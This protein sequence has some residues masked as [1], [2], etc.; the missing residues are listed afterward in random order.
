MRTAG[1]SIVPRRTA[2]PDDGDSETRYV[3]TV[4]FQKTEG[5]PRHDRQRS[6]DTEKIIWFFIHGSFV[7]EDLL[8]AEVALY[9]FQGQASVFTILV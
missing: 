8:R 3:F 7:V 4:T 1:S 5:Q 6:A 2:L 9:D